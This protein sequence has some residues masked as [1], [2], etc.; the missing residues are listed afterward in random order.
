MCFWASHA[1]N[2]QVA[3]PSVLL[4]M[5]LLSHRATYFDTWIPGHL[6]ITLLSLIISSVCFEC[7]Y[8]DPCSCYQS[9]LEDKMCRDVNRACESLLLPVCFFEMQ[10]IIIITSTAKR[11]FSPLSVTRE[12][13]CGIL[14]Y[15][16]PNNT[17]VRIHER[18]FTDPGFI[19]RCCTVMNECD[20]PSCSYAFKAATLCPSTRL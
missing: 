7:L 20:Q 8:L 12:L 14:F 9:F 17:W 15:L 2:D 13:K 18:H 10:D 3:R 16:F 19:L 6:W 5:H 4:G 1:T 11:H